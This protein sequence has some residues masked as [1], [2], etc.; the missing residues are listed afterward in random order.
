MREKE[1][2]SEYIFV[3]D[4]HFAHFYVAKRVTRVQ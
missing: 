1:D 2:L 4:S 3:A